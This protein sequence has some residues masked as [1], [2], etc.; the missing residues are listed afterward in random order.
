MPLSFPHFS[1]VR[2]LIL[3][4]SASV[5]HPER[6]EGS[7]PTHSSLFRINWDPVPSSPRP[8]NI[9]FPFIAFHFLLDLLIISW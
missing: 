1:Y 6:S 9:C 8:S 4:Q 7:Q 3:S 2:P 5:C